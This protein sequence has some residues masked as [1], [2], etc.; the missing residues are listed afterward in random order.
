MEPSRSVAIDQMG[1]AALLVTLGDGISPSQND[2]V[3]RL[4]HSLRH[5][6]LPGIIDLVPAYASL[7]VTYDDTVIDENVL[8]AYISQDL[9]S[10]Q[11]LP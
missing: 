4:A 6:D 11:T 2:S 8:A 10:A 7:L 3:H 5:L 1:E 9:N